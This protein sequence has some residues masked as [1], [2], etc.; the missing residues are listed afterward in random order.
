MNE[1][2]A[3]VR[4]WVLRITVWSL[5]VL[6]MILFFRWLLVVDMGSGYVP[7]PGGSAQHSIA[8]ARRAP[9]W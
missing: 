1:P 4:R 6:A 2:P 8:I 5:L 3:A 9:D 7:G